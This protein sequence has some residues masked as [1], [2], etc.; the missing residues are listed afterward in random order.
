[1]KAVAIPVRGKTLEGR[2]PGELRSRV[3]LNRRHG[4]ADSRVEQ[5]LEGEGCSD[6]FP[7]NEIQSWREA[8]ADATDRFS[9]DVRGHQ[10]R[11]EGRGAGDGELL[12]ERNKALKGEPQERIR[13]EIG[14]A[15]SRW[16]KAS[17]G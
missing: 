11:Q 1:V 16:M 17:R 15:G 5:S 2:S 13:H 8:S 12:H 7:T 14:P 3:G 9:G 6:G 10:K 4:Q